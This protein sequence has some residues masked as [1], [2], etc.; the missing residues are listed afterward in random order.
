MLS[1]D[2]AT[3]LAGQHL[4]HS[5]QSFFAGCASMRS[6]LPRANQA[7]TDLLA[8]AFHSPASNFGR[9]I[10]AAGSMLL[11]SGFADLYYVHS[12][13][14]DLFAPN[15]GPFPDPGRCLMLKARCQSSRSR[16]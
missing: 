2:V 10:S 12:S 7:E 5:P 9:P 11:A 16:Y 13:P 4:D 3:L 15:L 6:S 8:V 1:V 14:F